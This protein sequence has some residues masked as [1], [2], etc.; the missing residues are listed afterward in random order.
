MWELPL[1]IGNQLLHAALLNL[2]MQQCVK[3]VSLDSGNVQT[4]VNRLQAIVLARL[5]ASKEKDSERT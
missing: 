4:D 3:T 5:K 1:K 2:P